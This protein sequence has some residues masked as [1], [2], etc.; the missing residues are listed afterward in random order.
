MDWPRA[1]TVLIIALVILNGFLLHQVYVGAVLPAPEPTY[2][3]AFPVEPITH[4]LEAYGVQAVF[5]DGAPPRLP[6]LRLVPRPSAFDPETVFAGEPF[7]T[8]QGT[9]GP[10]AGTLYSTEA[11]TVCVSDDGWLF[12]ALTRRAEREHARPTDLV[13]AQERVEALF[14]AFGGVADD[15]QGPDITFNPRGGTWVFSYEQVIEDAAAGPL[16]IF[17]GAVEVH[18]TGEQVVSYRRRLWDVETGG[19][20]PEPV[21]PITNLLQR[22]LADRDRV[23]DLLEQYAPGSGAA[24]PLALRVRL[25]Y[26][27]GPPASPARGAETGAGAAG[28]AGAASAA[29]A[30]AFEG[31]PAWQVLLEGAPPQLFDARSGEPIGAAVP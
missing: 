25:G 22:Q 30:A 15:L 16:W 20:A 1:K 23:F 27:L 8:Q 19:A 4:E 12:F 2:L 31:R 14:A 10:C 11:H 18:A 26:A 28:A 29:G 17:P 21:M 3:T 7:E 9:M 13:A 6:A 24:A 5:P